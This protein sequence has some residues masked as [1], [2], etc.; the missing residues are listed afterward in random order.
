M[1][2]SI[3]VR[4]RA[5]N[6]NPQLP[7]TGGFVLNF[8]QK[9]RFIMKL[10][11]FVA[12]VVLAALCT[13]DAGAQSAPGPSV[14]FYEGLGGLSRKIA[15]TSPDAQRY[16]NQGLAFLYA[17]NHD[18]AIRAF[19][20]ASEI[21]PSSAMALWGVAFANGPHINN[22]AVPPERAQAAFEAVTR[23]KALTGAPPIERELVE[24]V[25]ARIAFPQ[26]EDRKPLE[27]AYSAAMKALWEKYPKDADIGALY[28]ESIAN[29]RPWDLWTADGKP[30]AGTEALVPTLKAVLAL[31]PK[32]PFANH[33]L[34][35][36][37]EASPNPEHAIPAADALRNL[38][39][40]LG[41]MVH[42]P[43]H[44]DVRTG[45]WQQAIDSNARA[46]EADRAYTAKAPEQGFYR[47]YMSHNHHMLTFAA[48][49]TGQSQLAL[50]TIRAMVD[51]IPGPFF[52]E[53][54]W[55]DGLMAA[56]IEVQMRFGKWDEILAVPQFP[57]Y[58][59]ISRSMQHYARA[60][61]YVAK[62]DVASALKEQTLF[63][64]Q[65][66]KVA[67]EATFG[68]NLGHDL[69]N[70]AQA[71]MKGEILYRSGRIEEGLASLRESVTLEDKLR[72]DEPPDWI[73]P[74]RH[75]L[76]AAL[77]QSG[78]FADAENVFR[79][80]LAK[81]PNNGW[82]LYGLSRAL[83]LQKKEA[84]AAKV[85]KGFEA[86]WSKA[87]LKINSSCLCLPGM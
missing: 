38:Q 62:G 49:M 82:S 77:L 18:E 10:H 37:V 78:R 35:H 52:K 48:M 57:E 9:S 68:N 46:I 4:C 5:Q 41:H 85:E 31:D 15:T 2:V 67:K 26:P 33:M 17:F 81:L 44:I 11:R 51:D 80:D 6:Y 12:L 84:E 45:R 54:P 20:R 50:K 56:P 66:E 83:R 58:V 76:G 70:V 86:A 40:G 25:A 3:A 13:R 21:D 47:L 75:A 23:A 72:Y 43:S 53:N 60:V 71:L 39:P 79:D 65:R 74:T 36:A 87:D 61:S 28:A 63:L 24:A 42:M 29:L 64:A 73:Q 16:F 59:P 1:K 69:L 32:H 7:E 55:A 19:G 34:I 14:P 27:A 30:T 8:L 22:T